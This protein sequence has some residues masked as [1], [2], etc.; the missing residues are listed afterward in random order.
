MRLF[1]Y[2][3]R[4]EPRPHERDLEAGFAA[5]IH[6]PAWF[7]ARQWQMGEHQ[8]E[9]ASTPVAVRY[10]VDHTPIGPV[11]GFEGQPRFDPAV[12]PAEAI[13]ESELDDWWTMGRRIRLGARVA[14]EAELDTR[15]DLPASLRFDQPPPP[16]EHFHGFFDG[17]ALWR[18]RDGLDITGFFGA[19]TP[20]A[21]GPDTWNPSELVY[22][23]QFE[24]AAGPLRL[25]RHRG[26]RVDWY[27]VE[28]DD[29]APPAEP[30]GETRTHIVY[31]A[32]L[33]YPGAPHSRWW[34]I[35]DAA[36]DIGGYPP[37]T[38]HFATM[39]LVDLIYT[40]GDDWFLFPVEGRAAQVV[41]LTE[42]VITDSFG[43]TYHQADWEGL[44][45]PTDWTL[46]KTRGLRDESLVLWLT[47]ATPLEGEPIEVVQF[48]IDE[49]ANKLW[50]VERRVDGRDVTL[51]P[52]PADEFPRL[53][54]GTLAENR[55]TPKEYAYI[56][57]V[58]IVPFW[59]PYEIEANNGERRFVQRGLA[60][61]S[62]E[63]PLP[64]PYPRAEVL[65]A[66]PPG[67][68]VL[69]TVE[70]ATIP[71]NGIEIERRWKLARDVAGR[72]V[73]WIQRQRK[74]LLNPPARQVRFDVLEEQLSQPE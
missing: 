12:T 73:L 40:H 42:V 39:L 53:N 49:Y 21:D 59:H 36:V 13:V 7:L 50:A 31:P 23:A 38:A 37:D 5:A 44:T 3:S 9:N 64:M 26:G 25:S 4:L 60:D 45:P 66:G 47:A 32:P 51:P 41:T 16:Y 65:L 55:A 11:A 6:D 67:A 56:P 58:G 48:G 24:S 33:E 30:A 29:A 27:S 10:S 20:P 62:R 72:P 74:P 14:Q 69:H 61:L 63:Q 17:R 15:P 2:Y 68:R 52:P 1:D 43:R 70:P 19:D 22:Q 28:S 35:E 34:E 71:L 18:M 46:F 8:G 54:R 57:S